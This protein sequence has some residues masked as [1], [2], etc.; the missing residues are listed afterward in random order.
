[1]SI[2]HLLKRSWIILQVQRRFVYQIVFLSVW[3]F[4]MFT[5]AK[6]ID[7]RRHWDERK[8]FKSIRET[9]PAG[10]VLPGW[11]NY[12]SMV[13]D[14]TVL[15]E[16]PEILT[17]Y[18]ADRSSF[19]SIMRKSLVGDE[20]RNFTLRARL[21]FLGI[22]TLSLLWT[23]LLVFIWTKQWSQALL[24]AAVLASSWEYAYHARWIAPDAVLMQ[25]GILT[26]LLVFLSIGSSG[27]R[28][29]IWL[30]L[31]AVTAG[32]ACGSKYFGGIFLV[33]V[34]IGGYKVF[35]DA[36]QRWWSCL[37]LFFGLIA[38]F[39]VTFL[40]ITPGA[41]LDTARMIQDVRYE[42]NHY[43]GGDFG[44]TV[45]AGRE[46]LSL[47]LVYLFGV[48]FSKYLWVS[49][50]FS[51]F[52]F[53]G[54]YALLT[55][56]WKTIQTWVF[57]SV[58][59]LFIPYMSLQRV[60]MVRNDLLL[61][62]FLAIL[63]GRGMTVLW[64]TRFFQ[65]NR[66]A[67]AILAFGVI[68]GLLLNF[69]WLFASSQTISEKLT[70]DWSQKLQSYLLANQET[71]FYLSPRASALIDANGLAN[72]VDDPSSADKLVFV[73]EEVNHALANRP[74]V[75]DPVFGPYEVNL[76]YYPSWLEDERIVVMPMN[77]ALAQEEFEFI[78]E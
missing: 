15:S 44:Y 24:S 71:S 78:Y 63:S 27:R 39:S 56:D 68:S 23:Y 55:R 60:M 13:Y 73:F 6:G 34:F 51:I 22:A 50:S 16:S 74:N 64:N 32:M 72:V 17:A 57:L 7:F 33:P 62:P 46:H 12:P 47:L 66:M 3:F 29:F 20:L 48:F 59:L 41:L 70:T 58:P 28:R 75:Y 4:V 43:R 19:K 54:L 53:I 65:A 26:I 11:Y 21:L 10:K 67:K 42:I 31:A 2:S 14:L 45:R 52:V 40:L 61:F 76:D 49:L 35:R 38:V 37:A 69:N 18:V 36:G 25:F 5:G 77:K 8:L 9:I 30:T 1:M